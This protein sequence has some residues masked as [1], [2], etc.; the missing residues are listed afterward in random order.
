[1][2]TIAY[3]MLR[4]NGTMDLQEEYACRKTE[5]SDIKK[6]VEKFI[7]YHFPRYDSPSSGITVKWV[8]DNGEI[9][10]I[11]AH[12]SVHTDP[13]SISDYFLGFKDNDSDESKNNL[14]TTETYGSISEEELSAILVKLSRKAELDITFFTN[15][16]IRFMNGEACWVKRFIRNG[17]PPYAFA[18][19]IA[20]QL[21]SPENTDSETLARALKEFSSIL[22]EE[23]KK[24]TI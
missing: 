6:E 1:M 3:Y 8:D 2:N 10:K 23:I 24:E 12:I 9:G 19:E 21:H 13:K 5:Y 17:K 20:G 11:G 14:Y 15:G 22:T 18:K 16:D 7:H 4:E